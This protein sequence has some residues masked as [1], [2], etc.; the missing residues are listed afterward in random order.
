MKKKYLYGIG[1]L[2]LLGI[3]ALFAFG[4][5]RDVEQVEVTSA[6]LTVLQASVWSGTNKEQ[7]KEARV[8]TSS[9]DQG[10]YI[11]TGEEG[12]AFLVS[13]KARIMIDYNSELLLATNTN[14]GSSVE[15]IIGDTWSKVEKL[16]DKG[17]YQEIKTKNAVASVR[18]TSFG[19]YYDGATTTLIVT[20]GTVQFTPR[21]EKGNLLAGQAIFVRAGYKAV[22]GGYGEI[23]ISEITL[24]DAKDR[25]FI[26]NA[27]GYA[28]IDAKAEE[29]KKK[30][31]ARKIKEAERVELQRI[32]EEEKNKKDE[33]ANPISAAPSPITTTTN[34]NTN[35]G[36]G[37]TTGTS[38]GGLSSGGSTSV[39]L[40]I[41][42][43]SPLVADVGSGEEITITGSGFK[44][45][46]Q[47]I[48]NR[49][50]I[51]FKI[52]DDSRITVIAGEELPEGFY[53][54][55]IVNA[56]GESVALSRAFE[57]KELN[58]A[59]NEGLQ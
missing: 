10:G 58:R 19:V 23:M 45:A 3:I 31:E 44:S 43:I 18:G 27:G 6:E 59:V 57:I 48:A 14:K 9:I 7:T 12:R 29:E 1:V 40:V 47:V 15:L 26:E 32:A 28:V 35:T 4:S 25:W 17:E 5:R 33:A 49:Q 42:N 39:S 11:K 54:V 46:K 13:G 36:T 50:S 8:G 52:L 56:S 22:R 20:E 2:V 51:G 30:E 37:V 41:K 16:L 55:T 38:G 21:D 24:E 53:D 34:T